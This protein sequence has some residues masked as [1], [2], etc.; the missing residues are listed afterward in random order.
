MTVKEKIKKALLGIMSEGEIAACYIGKGYHYDGAIESS[1]WHYIPF[2][3][4]AVHLGEN[5]AEALEMIAQMTE[6]AE[7]I[8]RD[9]EEAGW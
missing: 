9:F 2:N 6:E 7:V 1:G 8:G 5:E 4:R 3:G